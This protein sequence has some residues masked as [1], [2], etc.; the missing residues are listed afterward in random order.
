MLS[1][2]VPWHLKTF[3]FVKSTKQSRNR[4]QRFHGTD[5]VIKIGM[6]EKKTRARYYKNIP[7]GFGVYGPQ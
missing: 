5:K 2:G 3:V 7:V 6:I 1:T 4:K